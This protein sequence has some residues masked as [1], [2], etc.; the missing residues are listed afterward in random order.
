MGGLGA[1]SMG[2]AKKDELAK[3]KEAKG[4]EDVQEKGTAIVTDDPYDAS[5]MGKY[6][7]ENKKD[8]RILGACLCTNI[9][10]TGCRVRPC[11]VDDQTCTCGSMHST[12]CAADL[13][14][15]PTFGNMGLVLY[16]SPGC[17]P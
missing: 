4:K 3:G 10:W 14:Q 2:K 11:H 6:F 17:C 1:S 15:P 5:P 8:W 16:P 7:R 9:Y 12:C 13:S